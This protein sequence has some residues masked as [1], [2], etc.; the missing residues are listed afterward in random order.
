[1]SFYTLQAVAETSFTS[2]F[3]LLLDALVAHR[4]G[5][6]VLNFLAT[7]LKSPPT[8]PH[9]HAFAPKIRRTAAN[10]P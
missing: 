6:Y 4:V 5:I 10:V 3:Q 7:H 8:N 1:M 2:C 9:A